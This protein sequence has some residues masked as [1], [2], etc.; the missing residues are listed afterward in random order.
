MGVD[1]VSRGEIR[2]AAKA[3]FDLSRAV[4]F[5]G[6]GLLLHHTAAQGN[7]EFGVA[8]FDVLERADVAEHPVL[9]VFPHGAGVEENEV[10]LF[11]VVGE[12]KAHLRQ[13]TV[14]ALPVRHIALTAVGMG[15]R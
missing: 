14:D 9:G 5:G 6:D 10:R 11:G 7:D 2:T 13:H 1:V 4:S 3:G 8:V 12:V 15:K